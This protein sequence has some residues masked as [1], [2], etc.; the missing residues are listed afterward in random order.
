MLTGGCALEEQVQLVQF[1]LDNL[2][3]PGNMSSNTNPAA[4]TLIGSE[5]LQGLDLCINP[6][7]PMLDHPEDVRWKGDLE[8]QACPQL[9]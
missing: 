3:D 2:L 5:L 1:G 4:Q 9:G 7:D 8:V 6:I